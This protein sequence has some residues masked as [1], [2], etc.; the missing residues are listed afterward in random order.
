M[1]IEGDPFDLQ[2]GVAQLE[3]SLLENYAQDFFPQVGLGCV[4]REICGQHISCFDLCKVILRRRSWKLEQIERA[5]DGIDGEKTRLMFAAEIVVNSV[6]V[7]GD[8]DFGDAL[9]RAESEGAKQG[10]GS[11]S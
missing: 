3:E 11:E 6:E 8:V 10:G 9:Q 1:K 5:F 4:V 2:V 7:E